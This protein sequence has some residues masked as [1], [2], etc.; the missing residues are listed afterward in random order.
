MRK[1]RDILIFFVVIPTVAERYWAGT[2]NAGHN[3]K[4][5]GLLNK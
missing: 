4:V 5:S 1:L 2:A 3:D